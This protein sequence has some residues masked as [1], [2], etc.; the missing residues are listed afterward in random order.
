AV[1][2]A[3]HARLR[4]VEESRPYSKLGPGGI[5][6]TA[7]RGKPASGSLVPPIMAVL[8]AARAVAIRPADGRASDMVS[9][10]LPRARETQ[11]RLWICCHGRSDLLCYKS[12][13]ASATV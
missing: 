11:G 10:W 7:S 1:S 5:R 13:Y 6:R 12:I 8:V 3:A 9:F 4:C 2:T